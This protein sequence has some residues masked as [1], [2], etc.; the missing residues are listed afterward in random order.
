MPK[1]CECALPPDYVISMALGLPPAPVGIDAAAHGESRRRVGI[2]DA[3]GG[4]RLRGGT[5]S[6]AGPLPAPGGLGSWPFGI[7]R[8][9]HQVIYAPVP[10]SQREAWRSPA[11]TSRAAD[12]QRAGANL[13]A[14]VLALLRTDLLRARTAQSH[15]PR[16]RTLLAALDGTEPVADN[17]IHADQGERFFIRQA[18]R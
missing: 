8:G 18:P 11:V 3:G 1:T 16:L 2:G 7:D 5:A 17:D 15:Y 4:R 14:N 10:S 12:Y 6:A 13:A 9:D